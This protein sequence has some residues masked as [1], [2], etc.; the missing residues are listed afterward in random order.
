MKWAIEILQNNLV[1]EEKELRL[2]T[3]SPAIKA[4]ANARMMH[5]K[6]ALSLITNEYYSKK[7]NK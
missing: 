1:I 4:R 2:T 6:E 5:L 3:N 7:V